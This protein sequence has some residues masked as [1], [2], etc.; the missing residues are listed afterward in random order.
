MNLPKK[1]KSNQKQK[2]YALLY[3]LIS[4]VVVLYCVTIIKL[5]S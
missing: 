2:N 1:T 3:I 5:S 4:L